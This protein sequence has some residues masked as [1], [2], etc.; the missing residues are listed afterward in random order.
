[1]IIKREKFLHSQK[2][3]C[4]NFLF[5]MFVHFG[6]MEI[7]KESNNSESSQYGHMTKNKLLC[8]L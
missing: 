4:G 5:C 7:E 6:R 1:M 3:V 8:P 2:C